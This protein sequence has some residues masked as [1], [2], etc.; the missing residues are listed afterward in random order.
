MLDT[1]NI[2]QYLLAVGI[3][4]E[5]SR[6][7]SIKKI[8]VFVSKYE[9]EHNKEL[10][11]FLQQD[12]ID[13]F[14]QKCKNGDD[15]SVYKTELKNFL[16]WYSAEN[17]VVITDIL[18]N[19]DSVKSNM[20]MKSPINDIRYFSSEDGFYG[21]LK[22][23]FSDPF[24]YDIRAAVILFWFGFTREELT[25]IKKADLDTAAN[26]V[27]GREI[28]ERFFSML[29][30][31]AV[32]SCFTTKHPTPND[33]DGMADRYLLGEYLIRK[34][35]LNKEADEI[36]ASG[37][38]ISPVPV[39]YISSTVLYHRYK[40]LECSKNKKLN[41][42]SLRTNKLF[43]DVYN[44]ENKT[45][46]KIRDVANTSCLSKGIRLMRLSV[47]KSIK[48]YMKNENIGFS[49]YKNYFGWREHFHPESNTK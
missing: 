14:R 45:G 5:N 24:Y 30:E 40:R 4:S 3:Q 25:L 49:F 29:H 28:P 12:F 6:Y 22:N 26:T 2:S 34:S 37:I 27:A 35:Y 17:Q 19:I 38:E 23:N 44:I 10:G 11:E 7:K 31:Y 33:P 42:V 15:L 47:P 43:C 20:V 8:L 1:R 46:E 21:F 41:A 32:L 39:D 16:H 48:D 9:N 36:D 18:C 13:M